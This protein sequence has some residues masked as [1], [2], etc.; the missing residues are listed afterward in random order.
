MEHSQFP[1]AKLWNA[2]LWKIG[3]A[4][5][6]CFICEWL[7]Q[8]ACICTNTHL[9]SDTAVYHTMNFFGIFGGGG[10]ATDNNNNEDV[11][12]EGEDRGYEHQKVANSIRANKIVTSTRKGYAGKIRT[13]ARWLVETF[14]DDEWVDN[15]DC[16]NGDI[17][18]FDEEDKNR[19]TANNGAVLQQFLGWLAVNTELPRKSKRRAAAAVANHE[20]EEDEDE[21]G[22]EE[23]QD[24]RGNASSSS[25]SSSRRGKRGA[26]MDMYAGDVQT[27][28]GGTSRNALDL[29]VISIGDSNFCV[30]LS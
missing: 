23:E 7:G 20:Q 12:V 15:N 18:M 11:G 10:A 21:E 9:L 6:P 28:D 19:L 5:E 30:W 16:E 22:E 4:A 26:G 8:K 25:S 27:V 24:H 29:S 2:R 3:S 13:M 14:P 1:C 17:N